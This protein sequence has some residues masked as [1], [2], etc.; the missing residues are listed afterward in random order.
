MLVAHDG[1]LVMTIKNKQLVNNEFI[2]LGRSLESNKL[3][4]SADKTKYKA[5][6]NEK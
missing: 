6:F 1:L 3:T 5:C 2:V 4:I